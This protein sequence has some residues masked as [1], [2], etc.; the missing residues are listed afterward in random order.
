MAKFGKIIER[1]DIN[2][3]NNGSFLGDEVSSAATYLQTDDHRFQM[4]VFEA[5]EL[6]QDACPVSQTESTIRR[7]L[8]PFGEAYLFFNQTG[9]LC[10]YT[11]FVKSIKSEKTGHSLS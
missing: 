7:S 8:A 9:E 2:M 6:L 11:D 10:F 5:I 1:Q 3:T 4:K